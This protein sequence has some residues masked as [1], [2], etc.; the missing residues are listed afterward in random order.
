MTVMNLDNC[1]R[2][3]AR[4]D[5]CPDYVLGGKSLVGP[6]RWM[7]DHLPQGATIATRR[8][9]VLAYYSDRKVFDYT[10]GLPDREVAQLVARNGRLFDALTDPAFTAIWRARAPDYLLEDGPI[11][12]QIISHAHGTRDR[13]SIH[14]IDYRVIKKFPIGLEVQWVLAQ[15]IR[16]EHAEVQDTTK[17]RQRPCFDP[18]A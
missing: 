5:V 10:W 13:F 8:I 16:P 4:M 18:A 2:R 12:D 17:N 11:L 7:R 9:G 3:L 6:A 15:R 14:G 1:Q